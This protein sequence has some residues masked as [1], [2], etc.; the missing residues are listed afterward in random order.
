MIP[1]KIWVDK[2][3]AALRSE[4]A[5]E[6]DRGGKGLLVSDG[7]LL[8]EEPSGAVYLFRCDAEVIIPDD[9]PVRLEVGAEKFRGTAISADGY[10]VLLELERAAGAVI[11]EAALFCEPWELLEALAQRLEECAE[12]TRGNVSLALAC[13]DADAGS[14]GQEIKRG[15]HETVRLVFHEP[16]SYIWGPPGTGKTQALAAIAAEAIRR[17]HRVLI[18]SHCNVAVDLALLR[19]A[20]ICK[21]EYQ[22][23]EPKLLREGAVVRYGHAKL[24]EMR[25]HKH[26]FA[27]RIAEGYSPELKKR[28]EE[29]ERECRVLRHEVRYDSSVAE[30]LAAGEKELAGIRRFLRNREEDIADKARVLGV[31]LSKAVVDRVVYESAFDIV[32]LDEV[33]MAN[34]PQAFYAASLAKKHV[35]FLG[36]FHQLPPIASSADAEVQHWLAASL[37]DHLGFAELVESGCWNPNMVILDEQYRMHPAIS[38]FVNADVYHGM[39]RDS[40]SVTAK[41]QPLIM[42]RPFPGS[43]LTLV[44]LTGYPCY[45]RRDGENSRFN[46]GSALLCMTLLEEALE[47]GT[48]SVGLIAPYRAQGRL[49]YSLMRE[50]FPEVLR[51]G[52]SDAPYASTVH[53]FQGGERDFIV[54]DY[55]EGPS[56]RRVSRLLGCSGERRDVRLLNV[57]VSRAR[58]KLITVANTGFLE[59]KVPG[60]SIHRRF[61]QYMGEKGVI[62]RREDIVRLL[63]GRKAGH[64]GTLF[65]PEEERA[66]TDWLTDLQDTREHVSIALHPV[67]LTDRKL[68]DLLVHLGRKGVQIHLTVPAGTSGQVCDLLAPGRPGRIQEDHID[69]PVAVIDNEVLWYAPPSENGVYWRSD[70]FYAAKYY[71]AR[72]ALPRLLPRLCRMLNLARPLSA[73]ERQWERFLA[74]R[75]RVLPA[76]HQ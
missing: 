62:L 73:R 16:V 44:D 49:L 24:P 67:M 35:A 76:A 5:Y 8:H 29:L 17:N 68:R 26:L 32:L 61:L 22:G 14:C 31:T 72:L 71:C 55:T 23:L 40:A 53:R 39:L 48:L 28:R 60:Q 52:D 45:C 58:G 50:L 69:C 21:D 10:E 2:F 36:D 30:R 34:V 43:A 47:D 51:P 70:A 9:S 12:G 66:R 63:A 4:I 33:S 25:S 27:S 3:T 7:R 20:E 65:W 11:P 74:E 64:A 56:M 38:G 57:A 18:T 19:I 1:V 13:L 37:Y 42:R 41:L 75:V 46:L 6:R 15:F 54:F 59:E